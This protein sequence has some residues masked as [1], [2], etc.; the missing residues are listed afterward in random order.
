M[1]RCDRV[2]CKLNNKMFETCLCL[3]PLLNI[4]IRRELFKYWISSLVCIWLSNA[5]FISWKEKIYFENITCFVILLCRMNFEYISLWNNLVRSFNQNR[6][7][8]R[9]ETEGVFDSFDLYIYIFW[10]TN[11]LEWKFWK[12]NSYEALFPRPINKRVYNIRPQKLNI[13]DCMIKVTT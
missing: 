1:V 6:K 4:I 8:C 5:Y 3:L 10:P 9:S 7:I 13:S 2:L 11:I 12:F